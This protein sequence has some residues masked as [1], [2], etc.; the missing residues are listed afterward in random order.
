MTTSQTQIH[1]HGK[2]LITS[3]YLILKGAT[4]LAL[5]L[6]RGQVLT[7]QPVDDF[8]I[9]WTSR[10]EHGK[11]WFEASWEAP[12]L[13]L[14]TTTDTAVAEALHK[15]FSFIQQ[16][17]PSLLQSG[18]SFDIQA[19]FTLSWGLGSS[20][21]LV[22]ALAAWSGCD[23]YALLENSFGGSGYDI[24]CAGAK[25]PI[26]YSLAGGN[27][28]INEV[29]FHPVF[30]GNIFFVYLGKKMNSRTGMSYFKEHARYTPEDIVF[31]NELTSRMI[32]CTTRKEFEELIDMHEEKMSSIL[33][34]PSIR[35]LE[36]DDYPYSIK[37][38]G[39]WGGDFVLV[40]G[41]AEEQVKTYFKAK[42]MDIV[43]PYHDIVL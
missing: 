38:M 23:A 39:A 22:Y 14:I 8:I 43:I 15:L 30:A 2:F 40:M 25:G 12:S 31:F 20:S 35:K 6:Q 24:A 18:Y 3:E 28:V 4:G 41:D 13:T 1:A 33:Q 42:G 27:R 9:N 37:S 26:T 17:Q 36:F 7:V 32:Q 16:Q 5:P 29:D 11:V 34:M 21:T 10:D 19:D